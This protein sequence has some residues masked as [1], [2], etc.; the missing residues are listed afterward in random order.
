MMIRSRVSSCVSIALICA[1]ACSTDVRRPASEPAYRA[2]KAIAAAT[3]VGV[4]KMAYDE[5]LQRA[6]TE[7]LI[8]NALASGTPD[9]LVATG[10]AAALERY[11]DAKVLWDEKVDNA[12]YSFLPADRIFQSDSTLAR[13]YGL[14]IRAHAWSGSSGFYFT[15]PETS[16]QTIWSKA[17]LQTVRAD[18]IAVAALRASVR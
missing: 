11:N 7:L 5:L 1:V 17:E 15:V 10:Y 13:K 2:M 8:L 6:M 3:S 14:E 4:N 16:I 12:R 9:T 18:S